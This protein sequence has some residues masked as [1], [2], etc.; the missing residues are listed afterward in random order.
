MGFR[1]QISHASGPALVALV[2]AVLLGVLSVARATEGAGPATVYV[3]GMSEFWADYVF[4][5]FRPGTQKGGGTQPFWSP[6]K[7]GEPGGL[8]DKGVRIQPP[9]S[10]G[11]LG[12]LRLL[13]VSKEIADKTP[14]G[15]PSWFQ[16]PPEGVKVVDGVIEIVPLRQSHGATVLRYRLYKSPAGF[17][18]TLMN[19]E[20]L[21]RERE[22]DP[23]PTRSTP[24]EP[25]GNN[26]T[27]IW[28]GVAAV[29]VI[30]LVVIIGWR[31]RS[32]SGSSVAP[33]GGGP[34]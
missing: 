11:L 28:V 22:P 26:T 27:L 34:S 29:A 18:V 12:D 1:R 5:V 6:L 24:T 31:R 10:T 32:T 2:L 19:P 7:V 9:A 13:A 15:D 14:A 17:N 4:Y 25:A 16:D 30:L 33:T 3:E 21:A 23:E 8:G 20:R